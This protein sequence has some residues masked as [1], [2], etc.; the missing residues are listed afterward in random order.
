VPALKTKITL[1]LDQFGRIR[2]FDVN[3][4]S[5]EGPVGIGEHMITSS[6]SM[7]APF[8]ISYSL[9]LRLINCISNKLATAGNFIVNDYQ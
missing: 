8:S 9:N 6:L 5:L 7:S 3:E 4:K 2:S 1:F